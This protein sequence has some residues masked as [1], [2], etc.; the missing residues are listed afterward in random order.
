MKWHQH[1]FQA[2]S[3]GMTMTAR[4]FI[5][6]WA[7]AKGRQHQY[8]LLRSV[9]KRMYRNTKLIGFMED[10]LEHMGSKDEQRLLLHWCKRI[11]LSTKR[12]P[13]P[14]HLEAFHEDYQMEFDAIADEQAAHDP[15]KWLDHELECLEIDLS[16][17]MVAKPSNEPLGSPSFQQSPIPIDIYTTAKE[18]LSAKE[19]MGLLGISKT[20][21]DRRRV[22]GLRAIQNGRKLYFQRKEVIRY[23]ESKRF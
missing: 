5:K 23:L 11:A 2:T 9:I 12:Q 7:E 20:S 15:I 6:R 14:A 4:Y 17:L 1:Q 18:L 19:V 22:D 21:L 10:L 16:E 8:Q 3:N 13:D